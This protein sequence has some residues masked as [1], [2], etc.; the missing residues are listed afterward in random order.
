MKRNMVRDAQAYCLKHGI[1]FTEPRRHVLEIIASSEKPVGAYDI[2]AQLGKTMPNPKPPTA[3]RAIDFLL[4]HGF[5]HRIESLNAFLVC[6]ESHRHEGS[7]FMICDDCG[8]VAEAHLCTLPA[9]LVERT[10]A[11][12][13][14]VTHWNVEL[15]GRCDSCAKH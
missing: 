14:S 13:F 11:R 1:R 9:P 15:H 6:R 10:A 2:L 4:E 7:Q 3:Y 5:I 8:D 12:G